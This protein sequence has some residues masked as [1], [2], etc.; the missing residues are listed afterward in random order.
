MA[1]NIPNKNFT[2]QSAANL[3]SIEAK[4]TEIA[5]S[6][7]S[8]G[9]AITG[10]LVGIDYKL[11]ELL[12]K[13]NADYKYFPIINPESGSVLGGAKDIGSYSGAIILARSGVS[14][15]YPLEIFQGVSINLAQCPA[16][17]LVNGTDY[18][19]INSAIIDEVGTI[20][21]VPLLGK[22]FNLI[23]A[24]ENPNEA[25]TGD[26]YL[27]N[28]D[29]LLPNKIDA[30]LSQIGVDS[31]IA[32]PPVGGSGIRGWLSY[33]VFFL[34]ELTQNIGNGTSTIAP[35]DTSGSS[36][37]GFA[38]RLLSVKLGED[39]TGTTIP[40][41][42]T[43]IR[44]LLSWIAKLISDRT[45]TLGTKTSANSIPVTLSSDGTF[46]TSFG[47]TADTAA[48]TDT[49][50]FTF[51][52][53]VKRLLSVKLDVPVSTIANKLP[54]AVINNK[55][56][57]VVPDTFVSG[58]ITTRDLVT[59]FVTGVNNQ[60]IYSGT[61]TANSFV[62]VSTNGYSSVNANVLGTFTGTIEFSRS[63]DG[64]STWVLSAVFAGGVIVPNSVS[65]TIGQFNGNV[66][67]ATDFRVRATTNVTGT[68]N[69]T[70][71]CSNAVGG[72]A[73]LNSLTTALSSPITYNDIASISNGTYLAA[74]G[75]SYNRV[76]S[77]YART[78]TFSTTDVTSEGNGRLK[79]SNSTE[80]FSLGTFTAVGV[81]TAFNLGS[82]YKY[83]SVQLKINSGT[84]ATI[85]YSLEGSLDGLTWGILASST[86]T[87]NGKIL[88][89]L[90]SCIQYL[91]VNVATLTGG[92]NI[93]FLGGA[94]A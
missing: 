3:E 75:Y 8:T 39:I 69:I 12:N 41:G 56:P 87:T 47:A 42:G 13:E 67:G 83:C 89:S 77:T 63:N 20:Y 24:S 34:K 17:K 93:T 65:T 30:I 78:K 82:V 60:N 79:T 38:K 14:G 66:S 52:A 7:L 6:F 21:Y 45:N 84:L 29:F 26:V 70:I 40:A 90:S 27:V 9:N 48:T 91:R 76:N 49:G 18:L 54:S 33:S 50:A 2:P 19:G 92:A 35:T 68:V 10:G 1:I 55:L 16:Y 43:G 71:N 37:L 57:V 94:T 51:L 31:F 32:D 62:R 58:S 59:I 53:F 22:D 11:G 72:I 5:A 61:P 86:I 36:L 25:F 46:A 81:G 44:G 73:V 23:A 74:I 28:K 88:D 85:D 64:G 80:A 15:D 4:T